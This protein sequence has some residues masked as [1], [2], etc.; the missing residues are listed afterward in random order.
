M[1]KVNESEFLL[2]GTNGLGGFFVEFRSDAGLD[3]HLT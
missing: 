1:E 3:I 2:V